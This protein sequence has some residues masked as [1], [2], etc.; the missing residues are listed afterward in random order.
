M[1]HTYASLADAMNFARDEGA[2][3]TGMWAIATSANSARALAVLESCS[4]RVDE[5]CGRSAYG[6]GFGPRTGINRYDGD[7]GNNLQLRDDLQSVTSITVRQATASATTT[8]P[9][10]NTDYYLRNQRRGYEPAPYRE[11]LLHGLGS[12][13]VFGS[14]FRVTDVSGTW[15]YANVSATNTATASVIASTSATTITV[16]SGTEFSP[17]QT[18]LIDS[19]QLYITAQSTVTLTVVRG[20]NGTTAA[21]HSAAAATAKYTY[22]SAVIDTTLRLWLKRWRARDAGANGVDGGGDVGVTQY[23]ESEDTILRR[24]VGHLRLNVQVATS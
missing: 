19:E 10:A 14:G 17:G 11:I 4:R 20:A 6:S 16:S 3:S 12:V 24:G 21:T 22:D 5:W 1:A 18:I 15:G 8:T 2:S 7:G 23:G 13:T 9:A